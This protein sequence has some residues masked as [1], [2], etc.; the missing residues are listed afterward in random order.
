MKLFIILMLLSSATFAVEDFTETNHCLDP[1]AAKDNE[2]MVRRHPTDE[3][4]VQLV[5]L[6]IGLCDL[7]DKGIITVKLATDLFNLEKDRGVKE[8]FKEEVK[9]KKELGA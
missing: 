4:L 3:H 1:Q 5:A 6:R 2:D 9:N 8:K 7:V